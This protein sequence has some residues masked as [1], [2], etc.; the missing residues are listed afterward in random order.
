MTD[1]YRH[2]IETMTGAML[3]DDA[4]EPDPAVNRAREKIRNRPAPRHSGDAQ[5]SPV[6]SGAG[7]P[8]KGKR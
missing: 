8:A 3:D 7:R 6:M 1:N 5:P 4:E 2:G